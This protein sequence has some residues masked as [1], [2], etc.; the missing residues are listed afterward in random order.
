MG[1]IS[2]I[3]QGFIIAGLAFLVGWWAHEDYQDRRLS[4]LIKKWATERVEIVVVPDE[5][6]Q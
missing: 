4:K 3:A 2:M 6:E 1:L 5:A